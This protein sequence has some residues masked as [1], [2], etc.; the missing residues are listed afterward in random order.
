MSMIK[1]EDNNSRRNATASLRWTLCWVVMVSVAAHLSWFLSAC[2]SID[3]P[4]QN[5][6]ALVCENNGALNDT[7]TIRTHRADGV[8][9]V[10]LGG[11]IDISAFQLPVS[12]QRPVDTLTFT[13]LRLNAVDT[14]WVEKQNI[15]H[16]ES[17]DCSVSYFH[18]LT[19]VRHTCIGID[20]IVILKNNID[21]DLSAPHIRIYFKARN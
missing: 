7:L 16:F 13:T 12:Y 6:V 17:V 15:P 21:Y 11:G 3:C 20:S 5:K 10:L 18:T 9:T 19:A 4:V 2:S 14:V 8:D 1:D